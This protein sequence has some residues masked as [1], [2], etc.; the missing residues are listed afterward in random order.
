MGEE[1]KRSPIPLH[2]SYIVRI[3]REDAGRPDRISVQNVT[4]GVRLG[5]NTFDEFFVYFWQVSQAQF[6]DRQQ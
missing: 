4:D 5:F 2:Q 1:T 3:W 6:T